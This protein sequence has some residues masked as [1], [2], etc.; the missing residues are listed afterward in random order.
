MG[1]TVRDDGFED[2]DFGG[3]AADVFV[4]EAGA[5]EDEEGGGGVVSVEFDF[6]EPALAEG[7]EEG[8]GGVEGGG[9]DFV[10]VCGGGEGATEGDGG[11]LGGN[12]GGGG[13]RGGGF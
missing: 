3:E 9:G 6:A 1:V 12:A 2:V 4:G 7:A 10:G 5:F 13:V 8:A 11:G